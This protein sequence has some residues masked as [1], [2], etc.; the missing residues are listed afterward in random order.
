[1]CVLLASLHS[2]R[3]I[4]LPPGH[5]VRVVVGVEEELEGPHGEE[6]RDVEPSPPCLGSCVEDWTTKRGQH[7]RTT[8]CEEV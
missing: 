5:A 7:G 1:V 8:R 4:H 6:E 3:L 2:S